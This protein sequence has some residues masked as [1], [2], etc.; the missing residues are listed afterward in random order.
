MQDN[1]MKNF[2]IRVLLIGSF[3]VVLAAMLAMGAFAYASLAEIK[4]ETS[5]IEQQTM[6]GIFTGA[7]LTLAWTQRFSLLEGH[8]LLENG[9]AR[10]E[11][12]E[13]LQANLSE[14]RLLTRSY[15]EQQRES[16]GREQLMALRA[17]EEPF[18]GAEAELLRF[19]REDRDI[20]ARIALQTRLIPVNTRLQA[21][22]QG[23]IDTSKRGANQSTQQIIASSNQAQL[24]VLVS[25]LVAGL[26]AL[27]CGIMLFRAVST[28]LAR[29][30][31]ATERMREGDFSQ[32]VEQLRQDE[33]G[34]LTAAFN[35]MVDD[36]TAL[37]SQVQRSSIQVS[38]SVTETAATSR[39]QQ[40]TANEI[41]ATTSEIGATS[42]E[43][44]ATSKELVRT[45]DDVSAVAEHAASMAGDGRA[46]LIR[47]EEMM[48]QVAAAAGSINAKLGVLNEKAGNINQVVVTITKVAD[49]TNL[50]SLNAAIEAE[51]AG[52]YGRGFGVVATEIR[53]LADQTAVATYDIEQMVRDIQ[54]AVSAGV[55]GMDKFSDEVR[56][57]VG[58]IQQVGGQLS[59][60][61]E[62]VQGLAPRFESVNEGMQAQA[63]G[64]GQISDALAQLSDAVTQTVESL[65]QSSQAIDELNQVAAGLR[66][67]ITRFRLQA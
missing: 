43:I 10:Q 31:Q 51:K 34:L 3:A 32:R 44:S 4:R 6:P 54:S 2:S 37:I 7:Q 27:L 66:G 58:E 63:V 52:E 24:G 67:S 21:M 22:L 40:A 36:L 35:R 57:G 13:R 14:I 18:G 38:A 39:E 20:E 47:M 12:E 8:I 26:L 55:M 53:R 41:A 5:A 45:M 64:A 59:G 17:L 16:G 29:L 28:P 42:R 46:G 61:I 23:L 56:R 30:V 49:Q 62:Q 9:S 65:H 25:L 19:S 15:E 33:F 11:L 60:I 1:A 48:R 50:L